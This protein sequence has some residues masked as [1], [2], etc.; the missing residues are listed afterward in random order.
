MGWNGADWTG[1]FAHYHTDDV[2]VDWHG[3]TQNHGIDE[4]IAAMKSYVDHSGGGTPPQITS[5]SRR[6][7][8]TSPAFAT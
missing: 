7:G 3:Q 8:G 6:T 1:V 2:L 5:Q 4:H